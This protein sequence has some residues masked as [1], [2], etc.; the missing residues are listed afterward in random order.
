M[1]KRV[2]AGT[3][4]HRF[5]WKGE[6]CYFS[7][8][9]LNDNRVVGP[10]GFAY[11]VN[12]AFAAE[13]Y[14]KVLAHLE[15]GEPHLDTHN[16]RDLYLDLR[17]ETQKSIKKAWNKKYRGNL[18]N[19][20]GMD[21]PKEI[22]P[23]RTFQEALDLSA[24][25]FVDVR[26]VTDDDTPV[27]FFMSKLPGLAR[28]LILEKEPDWKPIAGSAYSILNP[29]PDFVKPKPQTARAAPRGWAIL[30]HTAAPVDVDIRR[31]S[32]P[33]DGRSGK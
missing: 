30:N 25:A 7:A 15:H 1:A 12:L 21:L 19:W 18:D 20:A 11:T 8:V 28:N 33:K 16:L 22:R 32:D 23:P 29:H 26:Y 27:H 3:N 9:Y 10:A 4:Y 13:V 2:K 24:R 17:P 31:S 6:S 14:L 5:F